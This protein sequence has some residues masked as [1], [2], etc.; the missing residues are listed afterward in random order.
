MQWCSKALLYKLCRSLI[1]LVV[2]EVIV[3]V[4]DRN[5]VYNQA[6]WHQS[7]VYNLLGDKHRNLMRHSLPIDCLSELSCHSSFPPSYQSTLC[8]SL[9]IDIGQTSRH[10]SNVLWRD[11]LIAWR[12]KNS[13]CALLCCLCSQNRLLWEWDSE[14]QCKMSPVLP[15]NRHISCRKFSQLI[16]FQGTCLWHNEW[17][18]HRTNVNLTNGS[19]VWTISGQR[20]MTSNGQK[21]SL[22]GRKEALLAEE[23][24]RKI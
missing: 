16:S 5:N 4:V 9:Q 6:L 10:Y 19:S 22:I 2:I 7:I 23:W 3:L 11:Y 15:Q 24:E 18:D 17:H 1:A 8:H 14:W 20:T 21:R 13:N 12:P